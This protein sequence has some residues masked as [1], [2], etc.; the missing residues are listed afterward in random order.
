[1]RRATPRRGRRLALL[2]F[3]VQLATSDV[4]FEA[5]R[6]APSECREKGRPHRPREHPRA[7][8]V[9][10]LAGLSTRRAEHDGEDDDADV[11]DLI[12]QVEGELYSNAG[13]GRRTAASKNVRAPKGRGRTLEE[14]LNANSAGVEARPAVEDSRGEEQTTRAKSARR[15]GRAQKL[16]CGSNCQDGS[17]G[18][19]GEDDAGGDEDGGNRPERGAPL[20]SEN[21]ENRSRET[22][23]SMLPK[24]SF[25]DAFVAK[26]GWN[27]AN[28]ARI[29]EESQ[30]EEE[31]EALCPV[32]ASSDG[33][34]LSRLPSSS[35][36]S[37]GSTARH[38][39]SRG[40]GG[41]R[42][43]ESASDRD[44]FADGSSLSTDSTT[45]GR[46]VAERGRA[47]DRKRARAAQTLAGWG[48][49]AAFLR[50]DD[51]TSSS[52][53]A[54]A[55]P[56]AAGALVVM[57]GAGGRHQASQRSLARASSSGPLLAGAQDASGKALM[58]QGG[59]AVV[60]YNEQF[61]MQLEAADHQ[62]VLE[63]G[64]GDAHSQTP[65]HLTDYTR[66]VAGEGV[67]E[68][69][70]FRRD[71]ADLKPDV[72][73]A[74]GTLVLEG[75]EQMAQQYLDEAEQRADIPNQ[76]AD[77]GLPEMM[78]ARKRG[79]VEDWVYGGVIPAG[80]KKLNDVVEMLQG[81]PDDEA[82]EA[83]ALG[84]AVRGSIGATSG[85]SQPS[86]PSVAAA[87]GNRPLYA[88][89]SYYAL[90]RNA[91][92]QLYGK[93]AWGEEHKVGCL[94]EPKPTEKHQ[95]GRLNL[96]PLP[97]PDADTPALAAESFRDR[98]LRLALAAQAG[99]QVC[100]RACTWGRSGVEQCGSI[101]PVCLRVRARITYV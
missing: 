67:Y 34:S 94:E 54:A 51:S 86:Q 1:M 88:G 33:D 65:H 23:A 58:L 37:A 101:S 87:R 80:D 3:A 11:D 41:A 42:H 27:P 38:Y 16:N 71:K 26:G 95:D 60:D 52:T 17:G 69:A 50:D 4:V 68:A 43:H 35:S 82:E 72:L 8:H 61:L 99:A 63:K 59:Q 84:Q 78:L 18:R 100:V 53:T 25:R 89:T 39:R 57:G 21:R 73:A 62:P 30:G 75:A 19:L 97:L 14:L 12:D 46:A 48:E 7:A 2:L 47:A 44:S 79:A 77:D 83:A 15:D 36:V 31:H 70:A 93:D 29:G 22:C 24:K 13:P 85:L 90:Q 91:H 20:A 9:N 74:S 55:G 92:A 98:K 45:V 5:R 32:S 76:Q 10:L 49:A 6:A 64:V 96:N 66:L 81:E 56:C 40:A 28:L